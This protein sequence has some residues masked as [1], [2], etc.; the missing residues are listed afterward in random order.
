MELANWWTRFQDAETEE[1]NAMLIPD[2]A[3]KKRPR[4]RRKRRTGHT[5]EAAPAQDEPGN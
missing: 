5:A 2:A 3:P 1:R 4:S